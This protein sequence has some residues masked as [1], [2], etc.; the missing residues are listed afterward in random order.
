MKSGPKRTKHWG[1]TTCPVEHACA[2][3]A[4]LG[5][6]SEALRRARDMYLEGMPAW[7]VA[8][9]FG[10]PN[11][12]LRSHAWRHNW[13]RRRSYNLPDPKYLINVLLLARMRDSWH[14]MDGSSADRALDMLRKLNVGGK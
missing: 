3:C 6:Q 7:L 12:A 4:A 11:S 5:A 1:L 8:K 2:V 14:L 10:V 13:C 9:M